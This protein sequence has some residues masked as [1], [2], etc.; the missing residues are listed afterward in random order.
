MRQAGFLAAAGI[1]ALQNNIDRLAEDHE[2]AQQIAAALEQKEFVSYVLP[3]ET[4]IVIFGVQA[5]LYTC[6]NWLTKLK[7]QGILMLC[8]LSATSGPT[9]VA[10]RYYTRQMVQK[11]IEHY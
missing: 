5:A 7:E 3:V 9:G 8:H 1:Y 11:T 10:F 2:H 6:R 4:N